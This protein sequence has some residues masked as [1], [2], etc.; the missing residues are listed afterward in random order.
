MQSG[1]FLLRTR[2]PRPRTRR[3][4]R[5]I[6][7]VLA[8]LFLVI[9]F[10]FVAFSLDTGLIGVTQTN[11]QI[12][13]DA[14][15]LAASQEIVGA[16]QAAGQG[17]GTVQVD[18]NSI[19]VAN[20][21][22]MAAAVAAANGVYVNTDRDI[23]FG[24]RTYDEATGTWPIVWGSEPYNVVRVASH[25]DQPN[26]DA[27]DGALKL[28]FGWAVGKQTVDLNAAATAFVEARD[29]VLVL[30]YSAS[31]ND[32]SE[33][34][35]INALGQ[36]AVED[37]MHEIFEALGP[38]NVGNL[39]WEPQYLTIKGAPPTSGRMPQIHVTFLEKHVYVTSTKEL[40][41]VVVRYS[42]GAT[43]KFDNLSGTSGTFGNTGTYKNYRVDTCWVKSGPN[44]SG[45]G[46]G[47]GE[48]FDDTNTAVRNAFG[49][50]NVPYP[51]PSGTWNTF[52]DY[53]R[54]S[55]VVYQAGYRRKYGGVTFVNYLLEQK[56]QFNQTP[57][58]WKSP[59]Y[60]FHAMKEGVTLFTEFL[61]QLGFGDE[62]GLVTYATTARVETGVSIPSEGVF[63][64]L[65]NDLISS[66][67][68]G[69]DTIQRHKQAGHYNTTTGMGDGI[70][71]GRLLLADH[72]RYGARPTLLVMTDGLANVSPN[73]FTLPPD[74][75]WAQL[76]DYNQDGV[77]DY[78]TGDR[79]KQY[80]FY[81]VRE[82]I[83]QGITIHTMTVGVGADRDLMKAIAFAG[84]G[85][86]VDV[87]GG[88]SVAEMEEQMLAAFSQIA[89]KVPPPKLVTDTD[90]E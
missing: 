62:V 35:S 84:G 7:L 8:A 48:R 3:A 63:V 54:T 58:L 56:P 49:L 9:L 68:A 37:N 60:P 69:I 39:P 30:D 21:K 15:A 6:V 55:N 40:S 90:G 47:Y 38:P 53:C 2:W 50:N 88:S 83:K 23:Q 32:D 36:Q 77:A 41:N 19:A 24:R 87:P 82:A 28:S 74:W 61:A 34:K 27:P 73:G 16:I 57:T 75:D 13:T 51:Y 59:H 14:A 89:A 22:A 26:A 78:T 52:I 18:A 17:D 85:I 67:Y 20:A 70:K 29:I 76:T 64:D 66:D 25:R 80:S 79:H 31:M 81:E 86:W 4:R 71:E 45:D 43:V 72:K 33:L 12:G 5:G 1:T 42:N 11:L 10:G 65:G 44:D 46:P